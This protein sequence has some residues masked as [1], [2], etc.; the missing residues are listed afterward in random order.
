MSGAS[1]RSTGSDRV[2][3]LAD[4]HGNSWALRAVL[5]DIAERGVEVILN[6]GDSLYGSLDP[7]GS[8]ELLRRD[9]ILSISGNQDRIVHRPP[10]D[11]E[12]SQDFRFVRGEITD[13]QYAWLASLPDTRV[14]G[15]IFACHGTPASDEAYLL[16]AVSESGVRLRTSEEI[17]A[18]L[19]GIGQPVIVCG[20]SHVP[21]LVYLPSGQIVVNPGSVGIPA[22]DHDVPYPHVMESGSPHAR[23]GVL[24]REA[25]GW[26]VEL[27][28]VPYPWGEAAAATV[29]QGQAFRAPW[30]LTGRARPE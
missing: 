28:A 7:R 5:A 8:G 30:I 15:E 25:A 19:V 12:K 11:V 16:E 27:I 26:K 29:R 21:R 1:G 9:L 14:H 17:L 10:P 4:V 24:H 6:L 22:Y 18:D 3:V 20:H 13:E 23:Y 2:A